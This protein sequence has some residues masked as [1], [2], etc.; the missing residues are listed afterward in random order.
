[1]SEK[2]KPQNKSEKAKAPAKKAAAKVNWKEQPTMVDIMFK[3]KKVNT[4]K[5]NAQILV[6]GGK[7]S[8]A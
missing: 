6:D 7:A 5:S 4:H 3:G 2:K 8:L 1:M